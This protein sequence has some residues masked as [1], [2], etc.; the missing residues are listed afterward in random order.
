MKYAIS[1]NDYEGVTVDGEDIVWVAANIEESEAVSLA[2]RNWDNRQRSSGVTSPATKS[3]DKCSVRIPLTT[4]EL[5]REKKNDV[6]H[7]TSLL[8][9]D[10]VP[11][12]NG[13]DGGIIIDIILVEIRIVGVV[14]NHRATKSIAILGSWGMV[15]L[16]S[17]EA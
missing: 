4:L 8:G 12:G 1:F 16:W 5:V 3:I 15:S 13:N 11:I 17:G 10:V 6:R 14:D 7:G 2:L 9:D